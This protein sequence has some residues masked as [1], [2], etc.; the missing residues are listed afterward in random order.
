[1]FNK[2]DNKPSNG[3][4]SDIF[5][6][7]PNS[8]GKVLATIVVNNNLDEGVCAFGLW[9]NAKNKKS[10]SIPIAM[11]EFAEGRRAI[12]QDN[13]LQKE[14]VVNIVEG[15]QFCIECK[16]N[17]CAHVGFVICTEQLTNRSKIE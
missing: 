12:L 16:S 14:I 5:E 1:M 15:V 11:K 10:L 13:M 7:R 3:G 4:G 8:S 9:L 6:I 17:D 2:R